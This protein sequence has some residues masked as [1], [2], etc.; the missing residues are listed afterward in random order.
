MSFL[1]DEV[2]EYSILVG[3]IGLLI[4]DTLASRLTL[5]TGCFSFS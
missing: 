4:E 1:F 3:Q 5:D 2:Y